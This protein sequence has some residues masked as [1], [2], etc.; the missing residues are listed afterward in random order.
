MRI[1]RILFAMPLI[2]GAAF[3][4]AFLVARGN[5]NKKIN[6]LTVSSIGD[7]EKLNPILLTDS[8]SS[9]IAGLVFN[10]LVKYDENQKNIIGE[11][12]R[13]WTITQKTLVHLDPASGLSSAEAVERLKASLG[14]DG[15]TSYKVTSIE[16]SGP[17]ALTITLTTA[18]TAIEKALKAALPSGAIEPISLVTVHV[19]TKASLSG[20]VKL[21]SRLLASRL[22]KSFKEKPLKAGRLLEAD[23]EH[24]SRLVLKVLNP[25]GPAVKRTERL[26]GSLTKEAGRPADKPVG[27]VISQEKLLADHRPTITFHL[28]GGV[29]WHDGEPFGAED[30]KFTYDKIMDEKTQT[31]RRPNFELVRSVEVLDPL[32]VRV[33]YKR[34]YAPSLDT[35]GVEIIPKHILEKVPDINTASFNRR[36][37]GTGPFKFHSWDSDEKITVVANDDY[38]EGRPQLD[39]LAFR[40][41]PEVALKELE[42]MTN[43]VD[44]DN[45]QPFQYSRYVADKN[46]RVFRR[47]SNGYTYIGW[48]LTNPLFKD[49]RVRRA[50]THAINREEIIK[51]ILYDLGVIATG[52]FPPQMWYANNDIKPL[53]YDPALA[54]RL[55][56]EAGWKDTDGD[57]ILEKD[58]RPFQFRLITNHGNNVRQNVSVLVQRQ[59]REVGIEVEILMYE[60]SVFISRKISPR[61][62]EACVLGWSLSLDPDI[63]E[64]WHSSQ[65]KKGFNFVGYANPKVDRLI[66]E[67][68][69]EYDR[70]TRARIYRE[71][72]RLINE[73]Q[74]YTFLFV[75]ESTPALHKGAFK[76]MET[77]PGGR[78]VL[79]PITMPKGGL[80]YHLIEWIRVSGPTLSPT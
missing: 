50:L 61:D 13:R 24:S 69:T 53:A 37:V 72:H 75:G 39:R 70:A 57:G 66:E 71:I 27:A 28:R 56:A 77:T 73:D 65:V 41:I 38:W 40:I 67:G 6:Q 16:P 25:A 14:K 15:L 21:S 7:A 52:P 11:L 12:A 35:W 36:P 42:F 44:Q 63:Y 19:D 78:E 32:T 46:F 5:F 30:V 29:R 2:I 8:A 3:L 59:L 34:P 33:T 62:F 49:R 48:N 1:R 47:L 54:K 55:L 22:K 80:F 68:R 4:V 64:I 76:L 43:Q 31:V 60:W 17:K 9:F 18:G 26:I 79:K 23:P 74:P 20:G 51:Y 58:G 45:A 10:G